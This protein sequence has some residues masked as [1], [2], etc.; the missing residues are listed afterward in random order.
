MKR[1]ALYMRVSTD[2]QAKNGD[3]LREQQDTLKE[4]IDSQKDMIIYD[5]YV[6]DGISGQKLKRDEFQ[7]LLDDVK[8]NKIDIILFTKL[9][10]W[11]RNLR[12]YLNTQELLDKHNVS[13]NAVSQQYYDTTTAYGRTFIAQVMSFAE[14]EAQMTSERIKSVFDNKIK[15]GEVVSG[16]VPFGYTIENKKIVPNK[17]KEIVVDIFNYFLLH[18]NLR[19]TVRYLHDNHGI[20]RDYTSV[21]NMLSNKKYIGVN[22]ENKN[23]CEPIIDKEIFSN[24]QSLLKK[25]IKTAAKRTYIFSGLVV[26]SQCNRRLSG[27]STYSRYEKKNGDI[28]EYHQKIYRCPTYKNNKNRCTMSKS[29]YE[30]TIERFLLD[31]IQQKADELNYNHNKRQNKTENIVNHNRKIKA[32]MERLKSAYLNE[33]IPLD[34]YKRDREELELQLKEEIDIKVIELDKYRINIPSDFKVNYEK[35]SDSAK[36]FF[37]RTL[38]D[39]LIIHKDGTIDI[40]FL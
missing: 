2:Q 8:N 10:R 27:Q 29:S 22:R 5:S 21:K 33:I 32:K 16:K 7:R 14:L 39:K 35:M 37:W 6:D 38:I 24:V 25:N 26:C 34:E 40:L 12:H 31:N 9:D 1:V 18:N 28:T 17:D 13:W 4:Y 23:Y 19:A 30:S 3:S 20:S 36:R 15:L 11:F